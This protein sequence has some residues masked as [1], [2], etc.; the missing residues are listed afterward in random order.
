[1]SIVTELV[2]CLLFPLF[3]PT[4]TPCFIF[5]LLSLPCFSSVGSVAWGAQLQLPA[6]WLLKKGTHLP[7][8]AKGQV[9]GSSVKSVPTMA[10]A[11]CVLVAVSAQ[12]IR[13]C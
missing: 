11:V 12:L 2:A 4:F 1:M 9:P 8:W 3:L 7:S 10:A 13:S 5:S 6:P